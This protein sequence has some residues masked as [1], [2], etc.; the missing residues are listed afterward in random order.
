[1]ES[2]T[3]YATEVPMETALAA[4]DVFEKLVQLEAMAAPS[5]LSD[6]RVGRLMAVAAARSALENVAINLASIH[7][8]SYVSA[9]K[10]R[11]AGV[12]ER[13]AAKPVKASI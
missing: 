5:M 10:S 13:L 12:E 7:D 11:A 8:S 3:R 1:M 9:M 6:L 4:A 2:A